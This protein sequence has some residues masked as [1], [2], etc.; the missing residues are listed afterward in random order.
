MRLKIIKLL[1]FHKFVKQAEN[2]TTDFFRLEGKI[3]RVSLSWA[4][5]VLD[6]PLPDWV[7]RMG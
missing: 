6:S 4:D 5:F 7:V 2:S 1:S 3:T